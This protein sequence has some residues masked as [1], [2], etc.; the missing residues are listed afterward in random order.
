MSIAY[1]PSKLTRFI[2]KA[3]RKI[4]L[5]GRCYKR[6]QTEAIYRRARRAA[7]R[8]FAARV[9]DSCWATQGC[10]V[11]ESYRN[12]TS[13][14]VEIDRMTGARVL[15]ILPALCWSR[16]F[17]YPY[18]IINS[19]P[20]EHTSRNYRI[21]D[22]GAGLDSL[23]FY[24]AI[25]GYDVYSLDLDLDVLEQ[26]ARFKSN[27]K[28]KTLYPTY[29]NILDLPFPNEYFDRIINIS[30]LEHVVY[31]L[32]RDTDVILKGFVNEMLRVLKPGG[33]GRTNFRRKYEPKKV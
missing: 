31:H 22:C 5:I 12:L 6:K 19:I 21:L 4:P 20:P 25:K 30:V 1:A 8:S 18:A 27:K 16:R 9:L 3:I 26:V 7:N 2:V 29:G 28:L 23:Q 24:L 13:E 32:E 14:L 33:V 10:L 17:E 15:G 11:D